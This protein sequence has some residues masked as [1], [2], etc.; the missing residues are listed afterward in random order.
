MAVTC[1][2]QQR[3]SM[4]SC[5]RGLTRATLILS[6]S[7]RKKPKASFTINS[8]HNVNVHISGLESGHS[9]TGGAGAVS[10]FGLLSSSMS[11][12]LSSSSLVQTSTC[13]KVTIRPEVV[14]LL[15]SS[16]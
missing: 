11:S 9:V 2:E 12:S 3:R 4:S 6:Q 16:N 14:K 7:D 10:L 1:G 5:H 13:S 15:D 8:H